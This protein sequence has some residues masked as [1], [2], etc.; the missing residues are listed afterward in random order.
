MGICKLCGATGDLKDSHIIPDFF[1]RS[2]EHELVTGKSGQTQ[3]FSILLTNRPEVEGGAKQ[4]GHWEKL[5]GMKEYL[6]CGVCAQKIGKYETYVRVLLYGNS[7]PPLKKIPLG[8]TIADFTQQPDFEGL[9]GAQKAQ[10]DYA[11]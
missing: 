11:K 6:L 1:I 4:R 7:P 5:L 8:Q 3:P 10:V 2:L 9:L